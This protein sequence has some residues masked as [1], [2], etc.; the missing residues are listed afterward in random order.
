[1]FSELDL[2]L[3][4]RKG[5][6]I[7]LLKEQEKIKEIEDYIEE[8]LG[9]RYFLVVKADD[10]GVLGID[11]FFENLLKE[12]GVSSLKEFAQKLE[13]EG[14]GLL[15]LIED[16]DKL[17][18]EQLKGFEKLCID[19]KDNFS[20][21]LLGNEKIKDLI[22]SFYLKKL[23]KS[24]EILI[25]CGDLK[26][27]EIKG[28]TENFLRE[29]FGRDIKL[30]KDVDS[31]LY[32]ISQ[33]NEKKLERFLKK[34][35]E[36]IKEGVLSKE[37]LKDYIVEKE[38]GKKKE[39]KEEDSK[40]IEST[41]NIPVKPVVALIGVVFLIGAVF[42][43]LPENNEKIQKE[44][45]KKGVAEHVQQD[46]QTSYAEYRESISQD[47]I[48]EET[49]VSYQETEQNENEN[50]HNQ[51]NEVPDMYFPLKRVI[52]LRKEPDRKSKIVA[53][54]RSKS[55]LEM[56]ER[57]NDWIK[58]KVDKGGK[59]LEG[60]VERKNLVKVP[61]GK[62]VITARALNLR[63]HPSLQSKIL[64]TIPYGNVV[65]VLDSMVVENKKWYKVMYIDQKGDIYEGWVSGKFVIYRKGEEENSP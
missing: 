4:E 62:A 2:I 60:W 12:F 30:E 25:G 15:V 20:L 42:L 29:L 28:F 3:K 14:K 6:G 58:I 35:S 27:E 38:E 40:K 63:E 59:E 22:N 57:D 52:Y 8:H 17:S 24:A 45:E 44:T 13:K 39:E 61:V 64:T 47:N 43:L 55:L 54:I 36:N 7:V 26:K 23:R 46:F 56:T 16:I 21:L 37:D 5:C 51:D 11:E 10:I 1:M 19:A 65:D 34:I 9:D 41:K 18:F 33:G 50:L 48:Q 53:R 31:Y 32:R 49:K